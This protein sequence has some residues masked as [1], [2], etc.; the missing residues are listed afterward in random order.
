LNRVSAGMVLVGEVRTETGALLVP[1]H[2]EVTA[3]FLERLQNF[4]AGVGD[5]L[6]RVNV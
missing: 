6:V 1:A 5:R 3:S 2:F 4:P